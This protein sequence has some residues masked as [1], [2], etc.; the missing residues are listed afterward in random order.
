MWSTE[1]GGEEAM[2]FPREAAMEIKFYLIYYDEQCEAG[3]VMVLMGVPPSAPSPHYLSHLQASFLTI[4][5]L[6]PAFH[7]HEC[8][9][10][11]SLTPFLHQE[12][13]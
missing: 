13:V 5:V 12:Q 4:D 3:Q 2:G 10:T 7:Q 6:G 9:E 11:C 1:A 8:R